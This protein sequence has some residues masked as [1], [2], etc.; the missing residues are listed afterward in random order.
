MF[1][2]LAIA[3]S[4][5][6]CI[7]SSNVLELVRHRFQQHVRALGSNPSPARWVRS[8][9]DGNLP[10]CSL[11]RQLRETTPGPHQQRI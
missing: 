7:R 6:V 10:R 8:A 11:A 5:M 1:Q 3:W 4:N 9:I 2:R